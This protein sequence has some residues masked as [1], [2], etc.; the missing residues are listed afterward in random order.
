[1]MVVF[2]ESLSDRTNSA[3]WFYPVCVMVLCMYD[4]ELSHTGVSWLLNTS[5]PVWDPFIPHMVLAPQQ[6]SGIWAATSRW[7]LFF[8]SG[9]FSEHLT[10]ISDSQFPFC[11]LNVEKRSNGLCNKF[12]LKIVLSHCGCVRC[13]KSYR[14][15]I[16]HLHPGSPLTE[17]ISRSKTH[18][19]SKW[20]MFESWYKSASLL[21]KHE[22]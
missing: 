6:V 13:V 3:V 9:E 21:F 16:W 2:S 11:R 14:A 17:S 12:S 5:G 15:V 1:M 18:S 7:T 10:A 22:L 8:I 20:S 19:S 4:M